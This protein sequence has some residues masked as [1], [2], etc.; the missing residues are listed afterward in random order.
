MNA[1]RVEDQ[2]VKKLQRHGPSPSVSVDSLAVRAADSL[3]QERFKEAIELF[4]LMIRQDPRPEWKESLAVAYHGRARALAAKSMFKEAAM[5][6]ENTIAPD[7]TVRDSRLY[8][9]CLIR[10][11]QQ[12]KAAAYLLKTVGSDISRL[13]AERGALEGLTAALLVA[14]PQLPDTTRNAPSEQ[15]RWHQLA[16]ASR[17]A[18]AAWIDG[19]PAEAIDQRLNAISL[20]SAFRPVRLLLKSLI[21]TPPD[22]ERTR[23]LLDTIHP[24]SPFFPF[25]Q[26]VE[27]SVRGERVRDAGGW[28]RLTP[29]Q[30]A[31]VVETRGLPAAAAQFLTR[32][33]EAERGGP[34]MLFG[35]LVKQPDLPQ[36]E[37]R[38]ACLNLLPQIPDRVAQFEKSFGPLSAVER[39]RIWALAAEARGDWEAA[40]R[41]W[42]GTAAAIA[43]GGSGRQ[44]MLSQGVIFRHLAHLAAVHPEIEGYDFLDDAVIVYLERS[45]SVDPEHIPTVLELIGHYRKHSREKDWHRL[46][47]EAVQRFP[48]DSQ[49]LLQATESAMARK[50]YKK[51]AGFARNLL[52][53]NP[54]NPGVRRQ[55]IELQ[56]AHAR[57]QM[58][59]KRPDLAA[60]ELSAAAEWERP[61]APSALLLIARGLVEPRSGTREQAEAWLRQGVELAGGGAAGWFRAMLEAELMKCPSGDAGWLHTELVRARETTPPAKDAVMAIVSALGQPEAAENKRAVAG[62]LLGMRAWLLQAAAFDWPAA[63]FQAVAETLARFE[64][65]D[66][67]RDYARALHQRDPANPAW[68]F[69]DIVA[70]TRGNA[71]RLSMSETDELIEIARAAA[72][73]EDFH[74]TNRIERFLGGTGL[75]PADRRR[76]APPPDTFDDDDMLEAFAAIVNEMPKGPAD[77][78]R[79]LV[80]ELGRDATIA[81]MVDQ[82]RFSPLVPK[83]PEPVLRELAQAMV[84]KAMDGRSS[85]QGGNAQRSRF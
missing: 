29:A 64:A 36:V 49:V 52:R 9:A 73:R 32:S 15:S 58:R 72:K 4:K 1:S 61:D 45:C 2:V 57:K 78:L 44:A 71:D 66:L 42:R 54:I 10:D 27:A 7:G 40:E 75:R 68:R 59:A 83:M 41:S 33:M 21:S 81:Q 8:L 11:G 30:Q 23:A 14:V 69:H 26:A 19:A 6:L 53:I 60:K 46:V 3:R 24:G 31:F 63:E 85:R 80:R 35:Y 22:G 16:T 77:N 48:Q 17:Q 47:D 50:A 84:A 65:F 34:G 5:V 55:M 79:G 25:R 70:R 18:L 38:S 74:A 62:L 82:L 28:N 12:Q 13:T 67:L 76:R 39:H 43:G 20:R 37:V 56:V 51:A